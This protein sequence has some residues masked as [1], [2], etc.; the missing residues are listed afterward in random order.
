MSNNIKKNK[1]LCAI[2]SLN[3]TNEIV[4]G[5]LMRVICPHCGS[6]ATITSTQE[7]STTVK[8]LYCSCTNTRECGATFVATLAFK[9]NLNPPVKN[10]LE[11]AKTLVQASE[12]GQLNI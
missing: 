8:D 3:N 7:H 5:E 6:K 1:H 12:Q 10:T 4:H 2:I 11:M 9:N